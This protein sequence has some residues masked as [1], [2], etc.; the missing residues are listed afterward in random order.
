[1]HA[2]DA[3]STGHPDAERSSSEFSSS[4][5]RSLQFFNIYRLIVAALMLAAV[6]FFGNSLTFGAHRLQLFVYADAA[7]LAFSLLCFA[8]LRSRRPDLDWQLSVQVT[9]DVLFITLLMH[10]S[11]G[12]AS[13]MGLLLL[14][15]LAGAGLISRGR[16]TL[17]HAS[18]ASIAVLLEQTYQVLRLDA[19]VMLY[20]QAGFLSIGFFATA[21]VAHMLARYTVESERLA[22]QRE[23]DLADMAE[24][25]RMVIRDMHDGV[26]VVDAEGV[27][28][29]RNARA[30]ELLGSFP[31]DRE[32]TRLTDYA[33]SLAARLADWRERGGT[34]PG[35]VATAVSGRSL[36]VRF[37]PVG[38]HRRVGAV[39]FLEDLTRVQEQARQ[40]KL[41]SLGRLTANIAHEIRNPLSAISHA[42]ELLQEEP[43]MDETASRLLRIIH[44][45]TQRLD[46]M[47]QDVLKL[48]RR[49]S[50]HR[51]VFQLGT[52]LRTFAEQF[53]SIERIDPAVISLGFDPVVAVRFDRSHLNQIMWNLC[54]NA[55]RHCSGR[56]GAIQVRVTHAPAVERVR[57]EVADDGPGV[58]AE[59]RPHLFE[60]FF[61]TVANGTGL[62]LYIARE[63][64]QANDAE[65]D[66]VESSGG[67]RFAVVM[68]STS[69]AGAK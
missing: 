16:L 40:M 14:A 65:L 68:R 60:P 64:C 21:W 12:I 43:G 57:I 56:P 41:A 37:V 36:S 46:R 5:W 18:L 6:A 63:V 32:D 38:R 3:A 30:E 10:A 11:G 44:D 17:F 24:V 39:V 51:E 45:N 61:T 20:V 58:P 23:I 55:L 59:Y 62:G 29:S 50:A 67:G 52:Y 1:M 33:P 4:H 53:C 66:Y 69:M 34:T 8:P 13:G 28:R 47:V 48:N 2:I 42:T 19:S 27:I 31:P 25:N 7:Y 22:A 15:V 26:L 49:D 9:A 35:S 54:R